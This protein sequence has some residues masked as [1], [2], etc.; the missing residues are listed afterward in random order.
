MYWISPV[1]DTSKSKSDRLTIGVETDMDIKRSI[2]ASNYTFARPSVAYKLDGTQVA[3]N[4]PR[5][6]AGK[7]G[8]AVMVEE[9]TTNL[10]HDPNSDN[11]WWNAAPK[12]GISWGLSND[13]S[14]TEQALKVRSH[15]SSHHGHSFYLDI[16]RDV[17]FTLRAKIKN[18]KNALYYQF[19]LA[20]YNSSGTCIQ[21]NY[22]PEILAQYNWTGHNTSDY[23]EA[24]IT[25]RIPS[26]VYSDAVKYTVQLVGGGTSESEIYL[27]DIQLEQFGQAVMVEEG[28]TNL[29][30]AEDSSFE[31]GT[32]G[33]WTT[34]VANAV[35]ITGGWHGAKAAQVT[36][37]ASNGRI[38]Q[39]I[40]ETLVNLNDTVTNVSTIS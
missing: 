40:D 35:I 13:W 1:I 12:N 28:T 29:F 22:I 9:G 36:A 31:V 4:V 18:V 32:I 34:I 6:E 11:A 16:Q 7:F 15:S 21:A 23:T 8:K 20:L 2:K 33:N 17:W 14:A 10:A 30:S 38:Q 19:E 26:G 5:F 25:Y 37:T 39:R 27:K 3:A 24:W